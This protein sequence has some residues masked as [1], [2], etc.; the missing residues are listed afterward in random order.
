MV[1]RPQLKS[2]GF[3]LTPAAPPGVVGKGMEIVGVNL[4][5]RLTR[6][7]DED[8]K[9][10]ELKKKLA[11]AE[12][13]VMNK[14]G[15]DVVTLAGE[16]RKWRAGQRDKPQPSPK[17]PGM[18]PGVPSELAAVPGYSV[19]TP[20]YTYEWSQTGYVNYA[21][22]PPATRSANADAETGALGFIDESSPES[23][24]VNISWTAAAVGISFRPQVAGVLSVQTMVSMTVFWNYLE[25]FAGCNTRGWA[26]FLV[27][28]YETR[29]PHKLVVTPIYQEIIVFDRGASGT[30]PDADLLF[31]GTV[32][33]NYFAPSFSVVPSRYY[34]IWFWCGGDIHTEGWNEFGLGSCAGGSIDTSVPYFLLNYQPQASTPTI[35]RKKIRPKSTSIPT[36]PRTRAKRTRNR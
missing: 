22:A 28:G 34:A 30:K 2:P 16:I 31:D 26:G 29:E 14:S 21:P 6:Q 36:S 19:V 35:S 1:R 3:I 23:G 27:Q 24:Q 17:T 12:L 7:R 8:A 15:V 13:E 4:T 33:G 25:T 11:K 5:A 10:A 20:P 32:T 18:Q 9:F